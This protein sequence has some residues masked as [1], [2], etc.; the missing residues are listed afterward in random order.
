MILHRMARSECRTLPRDTLCLGFILVL[1]SGI[2]LAGC[3]PAAEATLPPATT[4]AESQTAAVQ[5]DGNPSA[6]TVADSTT[7]PA[8]EDEEVPTEKKP[9]QLTILHTNDTY[10]EVDPCG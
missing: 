7:T 3:Q 4:V 6:P 5:S 10:G 8:A 2:G 1:L 9:F